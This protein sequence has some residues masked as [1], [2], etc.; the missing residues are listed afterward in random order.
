MQPRTK[1]AL[2]LGVAALLLIGVRVF[3]SLA[4][5]KEI[6]PRTRIQ[7][8]FTEGKQAFENEDID[9]MLQ[10]LADEFSW[11]GWDKQRL[12]YQ[13]A[14]F[15]R[16]AQNPRAELGE[17]QMEMFAGVSSCA[18]PCASHGATRTRPT[19]PTRKTSASWSS[20]SASSHSANG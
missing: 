19:E 17:L 1:L 8:M 3:I 12:R 20:S 11:G 13:L 7:Q 2:G 5:P 10:L 16:N 9:G 4:T 18:R 6:D 14:Q 15:F